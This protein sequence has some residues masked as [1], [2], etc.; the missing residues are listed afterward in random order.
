MTKH[1]RIRVA[2][3]DGARILWLSDPVYEDDDTVIWFDRVGWIGVSI[4][5]DE[6]VRDHAHRAHDCM[7]VMNIPWEGDDSEGVKAICR[8]SEYGELCKFVCF[9]FRLSGPLP[10]STAKLFCERHIR[11]GG[12]AIKHGVTYGDSNR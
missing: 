10:R 9:P 6:L 7:D 2:V 5:S 12:K 11:K 4:S 8:V 1:S 3:R